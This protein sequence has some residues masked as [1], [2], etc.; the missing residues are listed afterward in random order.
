MTPEQNKASGGAPA[1]SEANWL[2]RG[3]KT[4]VGSMDILG[5]AMVLGMV[6]L[7]NMD[8]F[9][10]WLFNAP[11]PGTLELTELGIVAVVYLQLAYAI[12]SRRLTRSDS[13]LDFLARKGALRANAGLRFVFNLCGAAILTIIAYG[14]LPR[15]I[16]AWSRGYF[17]GN[18]GVFTAPTWPFETILLIGAS[19]GAIQF[20]VLAFGNLAQWRKARSVA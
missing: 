2:S 3:F 12:R 8:V 4:V 10:R 14:Q 18:V 5:A 15:L 11:M 1:P 19:A 9:G 16:D 7:V 13:F 20:L 6:I 17:K